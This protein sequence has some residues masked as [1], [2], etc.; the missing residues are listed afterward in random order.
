M[1]RENKEFI[2]GLDI[3]TT[4]VV[5]LVAEITPEGGLNIIGMG[6]QDSRGL[7]KGVVVNIEETVATISRVMQ[8]VELMADCRIKDVYTGIAG[9]HIRS[10]NSNGMVAI[11]DKEVTPA[12][13]ERVIETARAMP[14]PADQEILHILTQEFI[15]DD[16]DGIREPIGM[17]G[18]RLEVKVHIVTGA[19]SAAQNIVKCVRRCGL[20]VCDLVLQ[21]LASS[22]AV[23]SEDEK[24]LGVCLVDIGGGTT[25]LAVWTQGAIRHTAVIPIAGDQVTNDIAMALRTPTREA[26]DIKR[27]FGCALSDLADPEDA[28]DVAGVDDRPSR[29]LSRRAL[30][31]VIQP[32]VE[33]LYELIQAE[34]RRAGF[35]E[36]LSSGI[37]LTGGASIMPGMIELG[38]EVF[39]MPVR[40]GIPK[41]YGALAD[42]VQNPR[43][44][45]ACGLLMEA[46]AQRKRG[47]KVRET[48]NAR[49]VLGRMRSWFEKNF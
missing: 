31:D 39:H 4:K 36:V 46:Q 13:I 33:E 17:S 37:V 5:A 40:L 8:E 24:D 30:A 1:S 35:E 6:S 19:V 18:F 23:L 25:D 15:I 3:G 20:E 2:V 28:L 9:S 11:K 47:L 27:K 45:T 38:E 14:I 22:Y 49:Q 42:V 10:F 12:D 43:F 44:A 16:Q 7:R 21:P 32:R 29:R 26:E 34:L 48:S 41:Y